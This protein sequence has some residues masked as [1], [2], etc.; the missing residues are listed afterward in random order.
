[1][2]ILALISAAKGSQ[3]AQWQFDRVMTAI[4]YDL[5]LSVVFMTSGIE[6]LTHNKIWN[7]LEL[8]GINNI[9]ILSSGAAILNKLLFKVK[10]ID[11]N[12]LK[13][14]ILESE[15]II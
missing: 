5:D 1:M 3:Q 14:L 7:S 13:N 15:L 10:N 9:Y 12:D 4:A 8:Y 2:K 6:Q 11:S